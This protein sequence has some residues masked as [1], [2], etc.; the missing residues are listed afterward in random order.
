MF[1]GINV[2]IMRIQNFFSTNKPQDTSIPVIVKEI[3]VLG[4]E[5]GHRTTAE[6]FLAVND[7]RKPSIAEGSYERNRTGQS[8]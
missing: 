8:N 2:H 7:S 4:F 3:V 6:L 1:H 5:R